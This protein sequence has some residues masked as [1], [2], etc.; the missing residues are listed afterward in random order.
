MLFTRIKLEKTSIKLY[1]DQQTDIYHK[2]NVY[3]IYRDVCW[4]YC[5]YY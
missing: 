1:D 2:F 5:H 3:D 4:I